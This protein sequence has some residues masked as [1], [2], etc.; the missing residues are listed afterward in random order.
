MTQFEFYLIGSIPAVSAGLQR[1]K[2]PA[3]SAAATA[4]D[5]HSNIGPYAGRK[6]VCRGQLLTGSTTDNHSAPPSVATNGS[7]AKYYHHWPLASQS[8]ALN[9]FEFGSSGSAQHATC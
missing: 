4:D 9:W 3:D 7:T 8:S 6:N 2:L 1:S 5:N